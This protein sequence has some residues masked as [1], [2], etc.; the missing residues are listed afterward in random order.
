MIKKVSH[1][2]VAVPDVDQAAKAYAL[3]GLQMSGKETVP[4]RNVTVGFIP[5]GETRIELVQ[6]D[7]PD[8]PIAKFLE[9]RGPGLQ[10]IC[11]EV[12]DA[13]AEFKRLSEA[14]VRLIDKAPQPGA[15]GT[16]VFFIHPHSTGG[17]LIEISQ[18]PAGA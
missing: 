11:F 9:Q 16:R 18:P 12:D 6:P 3:L 1:I 2:A 14:G 15:H 4:G 5:V 10:H 7:A 8:S 17:V 13:D